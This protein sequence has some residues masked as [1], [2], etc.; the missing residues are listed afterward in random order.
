[1]PGGKAA[2]YLQKLQHNAC[3]CPSPVCCLP[4]FAECVQGRKHL[5]EAQS[6]ISP[7]VAAA[8]TGATAAVCFLLMSA[9]LGG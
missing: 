6:R 1:M 9:S 3:C 7:A 4:V 8:G 5:Q 2:S